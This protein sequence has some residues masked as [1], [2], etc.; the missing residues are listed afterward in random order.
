MKFEFKK[1]SFSVEFLI[2]YNVAIYI[3]YE[4]GEQ[5]IYC[6]MNLV[7]ESGIINVK[8]K[9]V[10]RVLSDKHE[11]NYFLNKYQKFIGRVSQT[12]T[13]EE[14]KELLNDINRIFN[15]FIYHYSDDGSWISTSYLNQQYK[16][17]NQIKQVDK[18]LLKG[19]FQIQEKLLT[20]KNKFLNQLSEHD[21]LY[22]EARFISLRQ[23]F[24]TNIKINGIDIEIPNSLSVENLFDNLIVYELDEQEYV[25]KLSKYGLN[26]EN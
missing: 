6:N 22:I 23:L 5:N 12:A 1:G 18:F 2:A 9:L 3:N 26:L 8:N 7:S 20:S 16:K 14:I 19:Y 4:I 25:E 11:I 24:I 15:G 13:E 17:I 10:M 21:L